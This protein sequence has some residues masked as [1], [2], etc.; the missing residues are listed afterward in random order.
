MD[1]H[2]ACLH[3]TTKSEALLPE[4]LPLYTDTEVVYFNEEI[5]S[6]GTVRRIIDAAFQTPGSY[7]HRLLVINA[8]SIAV[9]AQ[10]A[11][12]KILEEPPV[13]TRFLLLLPG[14]ASLLPT[15]L[16]RLEVVVHDDLSTNTDFETFI[17]TSLKG[18]MELITEAAK[19]KDDARFES[20]Y[21][22]LTESLP[23]MELS[24][25]DLE[26][27]LLVLTY[28]RARGASKKM[29]WEEIAFTVPVKTRV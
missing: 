19:E 4:L 2:H 25:E 1:Y 24:K 18:R 8:N 27:V 16:S 5:L 29:L 12:L 11:L 14:V 17:A 23:R 13:T 28:A 20:W 15:V 10:Q 3:V 26:A 22:G 7:S 9:E 21:R 6:I